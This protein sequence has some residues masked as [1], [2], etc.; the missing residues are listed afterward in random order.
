[1]G[2]GCLATNEAC[3]AIQSDLIRYVLG[4]LAT[5][6]LVPHEFLALCHRV[7]LNEVICSLAAEP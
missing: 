2:S 6:H 7:K 3:L 4:Y 1:M 5:T